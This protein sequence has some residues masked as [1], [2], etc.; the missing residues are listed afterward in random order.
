MNAENYKA[1]NIARK[2]FKP[3]VLLRRNEGG[4]SIS[5]EREILNRWV[6]Y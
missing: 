3:R 5:N 2:Q 4:S 6:N 1:I